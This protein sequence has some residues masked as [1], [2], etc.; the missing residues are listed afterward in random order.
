MGKVVSGKIIPP[1]LQERQKSMICSSHHKQNTLLTDFKEAPGAQ[2]PEYELIM[3]M[4]TR[5]RHDS[6]SSATDS[7]N[8]LLDRLTKKF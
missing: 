1:D 4:Q 6:E 5:S 2:D 8:V 3:V 7:T